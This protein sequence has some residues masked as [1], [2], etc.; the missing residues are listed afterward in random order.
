MGILIVG[1]AGLYLLVSIVVVLFAVSYAR[2][3]GKNVK[4]W[5][6]GAALVM[7]LI[8]CW[9]WL[10]T[11]A[12]H[13][14]YCATESGFWVYKTLDQWKTENPGVMETL[15]ANKVWPHKK[16]TGKDVA[17]M[18]QRMSMVYA[19]R[20]ELFLHRRAD[21]RELVDTKNQEV[22]GRYVDFSTSYERGYAG[23]QG[24]KF[25]LVSDYC[26]DGE[27]RVMQF[28]KFYLQF[29]GAEK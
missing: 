2:K 21:I 24:W 10:P 13:Q 29:K 25:W 28:G 1:A 11:I 12:V 7:F 4:R 3:H 23:W 15:V 26:P 14:Y 5:G 18:N 20:H 27:N 19:D 16:E 6:W 22:L 8:P 17:M 9:D